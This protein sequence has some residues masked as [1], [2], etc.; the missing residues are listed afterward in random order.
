MQP[1]VAEI[2]YDEAAELKLGA[3]YPD[4]AHACEVVLI[5]HDAEEETDVS[6]DSDDD[7][8]DESAT[9]HNQ[10]EQENL[11]KVQKEARYVASR[12]RK[13]VDSG[14]QVYD[15]K[16]KL[17]RALHY[18][19]IVILLRATSSAAPVFEEEL[20]AAGVASYAELNSGYFNAVEVQTVLSLLQIIDN[21]QQDIALAAVLRS[22]LYGLTAEQLAHIR[23]ADRKG[24]F[25]DALRSAAEQDAQLTDMLGQLERWRD[26]ARSMP[27]SNFLWALLNETG[28][29]DGVGGWPGGVQ[30]QA[31]LRA[32]IERAKQ[33]EASSYRGLFRFLRFI[34]RLQESGSDLGTAQA[35]GER[36]DVVRIMSIHKSK[37]LEFPVVFLAGVSKK[38]NETDMRQPFMMH[39][40]LGY[41]PKAIDAERRISYPTIA[42]QA[43]G[44]KLRKEM[45]AEEMRILYVALTRAKEKLIIVGSINDAAKTLENWTRYLSVEPLSLP[46]ASLFKAKTYLDWIGPA[47]IRHPD[48]RL[49]REHV[50]ATAT[51]LR[52]EDP[53][54]WQMAI[55]RETAIAQSTDML[56]VDPTYLHAIRD[57]KPLP[58]DEPID[59]TIA[60]Q[61]TWEDPLRAAT[62]TFAK[63]SVS[64]LKRKTEDPTPGEERPP[65]PMQVELNRPSFMQTQQL[66]AT[67]RGTAYHTVMQHLPLQNPDLNV[68]AFLDGLVDKQ[69]LTQAQRDAIHAD[70]IGAFLRT[71]LYQEMSAAQT[72]YRELPFS[73]GIADAN[74]TKPILMQGVIDCLYDW[75]GELVLLDYKTDRVSRPEEIGERYR[76]QLELYADAITKMTGR[77]VARRLLYLFDG[78]HIVTI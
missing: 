38:F 42:H 64:E 70:R 66:T 21:P 34:E 54:Q 75:N 35:I 2:D 8:N 47:L 40:D 63:I 37:G 7:S 46:Q 65:Q 19:D 3:T 14:F 53:S 71:A 6:F 49:W 57:A 29:F 51:N 15:G 26:D 18:R 1:E 61:L 25:Y 43:I 30:R 39:R 67:E 60:H 52:S 28:Y 9:E 32:L 12:I 73:L 23:L 27:L 50:G 68:A 22:P 74:S 78:G 10:Q 24:S 41:G 13:M 62:Q 55:I 44:E 31:N 76:A 16:L 56:Q 17:N 48:A 59:A 11:S 69:F 4:A 5:E 72:V 36:E 58:V 20:R 33:F 77:P 45:L